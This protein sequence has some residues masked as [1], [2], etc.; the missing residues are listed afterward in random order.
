MLLGAVEVVE[1]RQQRADDLSDD[2][3][4]IR[5]AV[6]LDALAVVGVLGLRAE[7]VGRMSATRSRSSLV[8]QRLVGVA[9]SS[10]VGFVDVIGRQ[11]RPR[12][13]RS[14]VPA[15][16][17]LD[18]RA[19]RTS[20]LGS[21]EVLVAMVL[22]PV[23]VCRQPCTSCGLG[24]SSTT[25]ASTTSSSAALGGGLVGARPRKRRLAWLDA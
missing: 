15:S 14:A 13:G 22:R 24:S 1:H 10:L 25:S 23:S 6:A 21:L 7:H 19:L 5:A 2:R 9:Q 4:A 16:L 3:V 20:R 17:G 8:E 11:R 12:R 18:R